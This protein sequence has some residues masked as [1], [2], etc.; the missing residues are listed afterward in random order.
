MKYGSGTTKYAAAIAKPIRDP[1]APSF[2]KMLPEKTHYSLAEAA[3]RIQCKPN[4]LL[5]Y[6]VQKLITLYVGVPDRVDLRIYDEWT[7]QDIDAFLGR[8]QLLALE[9]SHCLKIETYGKTE[10]CDFPEGCS[11]ES[12]GRLRTV[13]TSEGRPALN[14]RWVYWRT[15]RDG[16]IYP[17]LILPEHLFVLHSDLVKLEEL[18]GTKEEPRKN[19]AT[20]PRAVKREIK[21]IGELASP[22]AKID[23]RPDSTRPAKPDQKKPTANDAEDEKSLKRQASIAFNTPSRSATILR[24]EQVMA[25]TGL[26]KSTIYDRLNENSPRYDSTFPKQVEL[27]PGAVG[28]YADEITGWVLSLKDKKFR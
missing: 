12:T 25:Q 20:V 24:I 15:Y 16:L 17:L 10:Q 9:Q 28:W 14:V 18:A 6:G 1:K 19:K 13:R 27:G 22:E 3:E 5:H 8:P 23:D 2:K 26:G 21:E 4:D 7:K 11:I